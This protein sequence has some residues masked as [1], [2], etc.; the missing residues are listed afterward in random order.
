MTDASPQFE[1]DSITTSD[2][3]FEQHEVF[4]ATGRCVCHNRADSAAPTGTRPPLPS[5]SPQ[6]ER[7]PLPSR[8]PQVVRPPGAGGVA[9]PLA[10]APAVSH[11]NGGATAPRA[12]SGARAA[13]TRAGAGAGP[14]G[15][16]GGA[17][18]NPNRSPIAASGASGK[19]GSQ[20]GGCDSRML[21]RPPPPLSLAPRSLPRP[22][23][24]G[25]LTQ[26]TPAAVAVAGDDNP[27]EPEPSK[28]PIR[29][30]NSFLKPS[31]PVTLHLRI[32]L[33]GVLFL[34]QCICEAATLI[35]LKLSHVPSCWGTELFKEPQLIPHQ[36]NTPV[37]AI[38]A[39]G[40]GAPTPFA[41]H[42]VLNHLSGEGL[43]ASTIASMLLTFVF[44][45]LQDGQAFLTFLL[46]ALQIPAPEAEASQR[47]NSPSRHSGRHED[48]SASRTSLRG[49]PFMLR[50]TGVP[51]PEVS[52]RAIAR[53]SA[54]SRA[55]SSQPLL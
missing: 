37:P 7:P 2:S 6:S 18:D 15:S 12:A 26:T 28:P 22:G 29:T 17:P 1:R 30:S 47:R 35:S 44:V 43:T 32:Q 21:E 24:Q 27:P 13:E 25:N 33:L 53:A 16:T 50:F 55:A 40:H 45:F 31:G 49:S 39:D 5:R 10:E 52:R 9:S 46:F 42:R 38:S 20:G 23:S 11:S 51:T 4:Q 34:L 36:D 54:P 41:A 19:G 8:S 14:C 48:L 3:D